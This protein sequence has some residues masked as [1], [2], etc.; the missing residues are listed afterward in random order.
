MAAAR[1]AAAGE[2]LPD[3]PA[4][5][6]LKSAN[7]ACKK[8]SRLK[9]KDGAVAK[10]RAPPAPETKPKAKKPN[11][12]ALAL[13][14]SLETANAAKAGPVP[15]KS[16]SSGKAKAANGHEAA[17]SPGK[18]TS[19]AEGMAEPADSDDSSGVAPAQ[20]VPEGL[21]ALF[22]PAKPP[23]VAP[24]V[25][26]PSAEEGDADNHFPLPASF[27]QLRGCASS[28]ETSSSQLIGAGPHPAYPT[29]PRIPAALSRLS[30]HGQ[31]NA[32]ALDLS[33]QPSVQPITPPR[34]VRSRP[35]GPAVGSIHPA[36]SS[37]QAADNLP[38]SSHSAPQPSVVEEPLRPALGRASNVAPAH[39]LRYSEAP[40]S[41]AETSGPVE[42]DLEDE[43]PVEVSQ[44]QQ[45]APR[46]VQQQ[47]SGPQPFQMPLFDPFQHQQQ[48]QTALL[49]HFASLPLH[50]WGDALGEYQRQALASLAS[51]ISAVQ[52]VLAQASLLQQ[53]QQQA[54]LQG[55]H[56]TSW[57]RPVSVISIGTAG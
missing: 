41:H 37:P 43:L 50:Q 39:D 34:R 1:A 20:G 47:L 27:L 18:G 13:R 36:A 55:A 45:Q 23:I 16:P 35:G 29:V 30:P 5:K 10:R 52:Q 33:R 54:T 32:A 28:E 26:G 57:Y 14:L 25:T 19:V 2:P 56:L 22:S 48:Q 6:A 17:G 53:Q 31:G 8:A 15:K 51:N 11:P 7:L 9:V 40:A 21:L 3:L 4:L 42:I 46:Q 24:A 12:L 38:A 44:Q 49:A